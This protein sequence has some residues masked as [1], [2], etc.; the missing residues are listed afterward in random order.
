MRAS[1]VSSGGCAGCRASQLLN[2]GQAIP[3]GKKHFPH[4]G[5]RHDFVVE[6]ADGHSGLVVGSVLEDAAALQRVVGQ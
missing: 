5:V 2:E 6:L 1:R 3:D 4:R